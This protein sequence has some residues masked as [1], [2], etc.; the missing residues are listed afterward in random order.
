VNDRRCFFLLVL[1]VLVILA[2]G[3]IFAGAFDPI[4]SGARAVGMGGAYTAVADDPNSVV[5]NPAGLAGVRRPGIAVNHLDVQ[6]LG[7][8]SYDQLIYAQPFVYRNAVAASWL[9]LGTTGLVSYLNYTENTFILTYQQSI[10]QNLSLGLNF[11]VFQV[12]YDNAAAGW[13]LDLG[14]RY[15][16]IPALAVAM[17]GEN[18]NS[19]ELD[20]S[21]GIADRLPLNLRVGLAVY[22]VPGT[23]V[24]LDAD[25]LADSNRKPQLH[26]GAEEVL[27]E[28]LLA[29][30]AGVAYNMDE[31]RFMP[32][33]GLGVR[34]SFLE[35]AYAYS[36]HFDFDGNH[37]LSLNWGF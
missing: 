11:K 6:T 23:T 20:W 1:A 14:A 13:G 15:Q 18:I 27:F 26:F 34:I 21:S 3:K 7:L 2:P 25:R 24:S 29:L 8:L 28:R 17:V 30:R 36:A 12:Q 19:P 5:W 33:G 35:L 31:G 9:R 4:P 16:I 37:V 22:P 10:I 32:S